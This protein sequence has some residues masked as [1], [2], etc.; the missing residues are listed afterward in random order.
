MNDANIDFY[1]RIGAN[2]LREMAVLQGLER[3]PE[4]PLLM[5]FIRD[6]QLLIEIGAGYG[7]I[8]KALKT[9][10]FKGK[11]VAQE[12]CPELCQVLRE[13]CSQDAVIFEGDIKREHYPQNSDALLW[14]WSGMLEFTPEEQ[15]AVIGQL[16]AHLNP[17]G[18][19]AL[20][21]PREIRYV[22][23]PIDERKIVVDTEWGRID[24]YLPLE[25]EL[26]NYGLRAGFRHLETIH[27]QT[28]T[29]LKR[30]LY[31]FVKD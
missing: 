8:V 28:D 18:V 21:I 25:E 7:R 16:F 26:I 31:L 4:I 14:M 19:L 15:Q 22:G 29:G 6:A 1:R 5:P 23:K 3:G 12:R 24:A 10:G 17:G 30:S 13:E 11:I 2:K 20:E 9:N 27:Y